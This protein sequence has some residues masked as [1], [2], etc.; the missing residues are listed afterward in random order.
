MLN[1]VGRIHGKFLECGSDWIELIIIQNNRDRGEAA[2]ALL[3]A[4]IK[5]SLQFGTPDRARGSELIYQMAQGLGLS[6][7]GAESTSSG[8]AK[9]SPMWTGRWESVIEREVGRRIWWNLVF[10]DWALSPSYNFSCSI[11]PDQSKSTQLLS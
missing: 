6:R 1:S 7:L 11:H 10:L 2:W 3:G 8:Q 4:A 9:S 5:V